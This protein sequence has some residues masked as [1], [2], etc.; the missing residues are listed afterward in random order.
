VGDSG[1][2]RRRQD[3]TVSYNAS[4]VEGVLREIGLDIVNETGN[5]FLCYCPFHGNR[6]TPSFSVSKVYGEYLCFNAS[7]SQHG[8]LVEL[9]KSQTKKGEFPAR[10]LISSH[11]HEKV[12]SFAEKLKAAIE[13]DV[14]W[15]FWPQDT[16]DRLH[17]DFWNWQPAV[18]YMMV[19]R[20]FDEDTLN[21]FSIGYSAKQDFVVVPAHN[22][23]GKPIGVIGRRPDKEDKKFKNSPGLP[24]S[25]FLWNYHRAKRSG[26]V[27]IV[28]EAS[29]DAM[30]IHQ[31]GYPNVVACLGGNYSP[32]HAELLAKTFNTILL[33]TDFD[34]KNKHIYDDCKKCKKLGLNLCK[35]H[36]A[37]RDLGQKIAEAH[38]NKRIMWASYEPKMVYPHNAKDAGD[39]TDEE[40]RHC[41]RNAATNFTYRSWGLY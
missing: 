33:F 3:N 36:N 1:N 28:C 27:V 24:T 30:R 38:T 29:F 5:D 25:K 34:D 23:D 17:E 7:C 35:G 22:P 37:G 11:R 21:D 9:V 41:I 20:G 26:D 32:Y 8:S 12:A 39:L 16:L 40:I 14:Q 15:K 2:N 31:A 19:E 10:R 18:D 6:Y 13:P 4:Q